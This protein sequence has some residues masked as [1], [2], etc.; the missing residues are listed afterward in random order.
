[1]RQVTET[2]ATELLA[3]D[4]VISSAEPFR[5]EFIDRARNLGLNTALTVSFRSVAVHGGK[6]ELAQVKAVQTAYPVKGP[7]A[8]LG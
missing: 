2:Q 4:L 1:M 5:Q 8:N 6:L 7:A 3:A